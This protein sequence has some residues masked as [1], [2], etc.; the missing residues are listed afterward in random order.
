MQNIFSGIRMSGKNICKSCTIRQLASFLPIGCLWSSKNSCFFLNLKEFLIFLLTHN[1][2]DPSS[3]KKILNAVSD[4]S[5]RFNPD[6]RFKRYS[7]FPM[8][9]KSWD[10]KRNEE[11]S[12]ELNGMK[13]WT[14][15]RCK[16]DALLKEKELKVEIQLLPFKK[17]GMTLD[18][19]TLLYKITKIKY[20]SHILI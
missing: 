16:K 7:D 1:G 8:C 2:M 9:K 6:S 12:C 14:T 10:N 13:G 19:D 18:F 20:F 11:K 15:K 5:I 17:L 3:I 4:Q